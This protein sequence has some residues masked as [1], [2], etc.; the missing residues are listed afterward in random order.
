MHKRPLQGPPAWLQR[1]RATI[2]LHADS[3]NRGKTYGIGE[4]FS[5]LFVSLC[6]STLKKI[7]AGIGLDNIDQWCG[8]SFDGHCISVMN[9]S[10]EH[11]FIRC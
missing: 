10:S 11:R 2:L 5:S 9:A 7:S 4:K 6:L 1:S 8:F 3:E